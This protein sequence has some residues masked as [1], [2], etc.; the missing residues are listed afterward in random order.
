MAFF[1]NYGSK[2]SKILEIF[3]QILEI[4]FLKKIGP[5]E[6]PIWNYRY[7][8]SVKFIVNAASIEDDLN[9]HDTFMLFRIT[10]NEKSR[11]VGI[12]VLVRYGQILTS[13]YFG[14]TVGTFLDI[15]GGFFTFLPIKVLISTNI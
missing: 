6:A 2:V 12:L 15:R 9:F 3:L 4:Q 7:L 5:Y 14:L 1:R 11:F 8:G 10:Y 13:H